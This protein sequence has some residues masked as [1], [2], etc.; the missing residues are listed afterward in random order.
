MGLV[1]VDDA[2]AAK[3][4]TDAHAAS[5]R[6]GRRNGGGMKGGSAQRATS[7]ERA[8][9]TLVTTGDPHA[10]ALPGAG[11]PAPAAPVSAPAGQQGGRYASF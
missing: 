10:T 8:G 4:I 3:K 2:V 5:G 1:I 9:F 6:G 7:G 11:E